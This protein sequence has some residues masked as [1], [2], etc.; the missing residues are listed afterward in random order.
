MVKFSGS[1]TQTTF[2]SVWILIILFMCIVTIIPNYYWYVVS[3]EKIHPKLQKKKKRK[4]K[5]RNNLE[6]N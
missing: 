5:K 4:E 6:R 1:S 2:H 3:I